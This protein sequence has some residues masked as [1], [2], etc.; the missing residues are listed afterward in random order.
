MYSYSEKIEHFNFGALS[1][2]NFFKNNEKE[3]ELNYNDIQNFTQENTGESIKMN[4]ENYENP[5]SI[6]DDQIINF[7]SSPNEDFNKDPELPDLN[8]VLT[9]IDKNEKEKEKKEQSVTKPK[10]SFKII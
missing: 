4:P 5:H 7:F 3:N 8:K 1:C 9:I 2:S 10:G 6:H